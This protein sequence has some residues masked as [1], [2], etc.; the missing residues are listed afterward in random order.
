MYLFKYS[1]IKI[2]NNLNLYIQQLVFIFIAIIFV[3]VLLNFQDASK[4]RIIKEINFYDQSVLT[5]IGG[6]SN[7]YPDGFYPT[8]DQLDTARSTLSKITFYKNTL[9]KIDTAQNVH[10]IAA[11]SD[12]VDTGVPSRNL[13]YLYHLISEKIELLYGTTWQESSN[14]KVM[15]VDED[16]AKIVFGYVNVVGQKLNFLDNEFT[17]IGVVSSDSYRKQ[18]IE[19]FIKQGITYDEQSINTTAYIPVR[20]YEDINGSITNYDYIITK[21]HAEEDTIQRLKEIFNMQ[22]EQ[23]LQTIDYVMNR[24]MMDNQTYFWIITV[25]TSIFGILGIINIA[26]ITSYTFLSDK[27]K[28]GIYKLLGATDLKLLKLNLVETVVTSTSTISVSLLLSYIILVLISLINDVFSYINWIQSLYYSGFLFVMTFLII[29]LVNM[30]ISL[31]H[32]NKK[33]RYF[34]LGEQS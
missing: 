27:R 18:Q 5:V 8:I 21:M 9:E 17:I 29:L 11:T 24:M 14:E 32:F 1:I 26:N 2:K 12:F 22:D 20:T 15:V 7:E 28:L 19:D 6:V 31:L 4:N 33:S 13:K 16:T 10:V 30:L 3:F 25:L 23:L 34:I